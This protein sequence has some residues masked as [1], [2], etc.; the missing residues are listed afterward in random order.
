V[1]NL[2][3]ALGY[4]RFNL[5]GISDGTYLA[6]RIMTNDPDR[7]RSVVL[8]STVL[9]QVN[10]LALGIRSREVSFL[11]LVEDCEASAACRAAYPNLTEI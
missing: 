3:A 9:M 4:D 7:V 5:Y 1:V 6:Q 2:I 10:M 8:G 11:N